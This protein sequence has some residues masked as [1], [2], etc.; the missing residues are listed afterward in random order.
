MQNNSREVEFSSGKTGIVF[1]EE[2][3]AGGE[4]VMIVDYK[5]D[6]LVRKETEIEKQVE[7]IWRSVTG[8]AE[9]RGISNV[10]IKYRF[11]DPTSDSDEEVYSGLLFEA[12]KIE[13]G[14]W[15]LR[16]VN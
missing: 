13:N 11:R 8:E 7:E 4:R 3:T 1:L 2:E 6:D 10:V 14:T 16:R 5:N 12:E 9:E 15:K